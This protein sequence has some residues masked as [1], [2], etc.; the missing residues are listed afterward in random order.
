MG[1]RVLY[2]MCLGGLIQHN[3]PRDRLKFERKTEYILGWN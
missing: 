1:V 2:I 3:D